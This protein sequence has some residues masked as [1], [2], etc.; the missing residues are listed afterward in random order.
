LLLLLLVTDR[1]DLRAHRDQF[2]L[3]LLPVALGDQL[4]HLLHLGARGQRHL[5]VANL[6]GRAEEHGAQSVERVTG[7]GAGDDGAEAADAQRRRRDRA[8]HTESAAAAPR[9]AGVDLPHI[10][11]HRAGA[12]ES[13]WLLGQAGVERGC[14]L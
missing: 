2:L 8:H 12:D 1:G 3:G 4:L 13:A 9:G 6:L 7:T 10:G 5:I 11:I 14:G